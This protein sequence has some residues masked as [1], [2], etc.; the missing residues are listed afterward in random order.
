MSVVVFESVR[1]IQAQFQP[2]EE[3]AYGLH[4]HNG[5]SHLSISAAI[6]VPTYRPRERTIV[7]DR[8]FHR[9]HMGMPKIHRLWEI[10]T[11]HGKVPTPFR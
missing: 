11:A 10:L 2:A 8:Q 6:C 5:R 9:M 1:N 7:A 4:I 3:A